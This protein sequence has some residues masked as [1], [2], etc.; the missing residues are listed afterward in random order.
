[1]G[2]GKRD[3]KQ[4]MAQ[5]IKGMDSVYIKHTHSHQDK[6]PAPLYETSPPWEV[7]G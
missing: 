4:D 3:I 7:P 5:A 1:L 2:D 6:R